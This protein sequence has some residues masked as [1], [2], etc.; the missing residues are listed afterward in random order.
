MIEIKYSYLQ[1]AER[2]Q[3]KKNFISL[4]FNWFG[5]LFY[6]LNNWHLIKDIKIA[7]SLNIFVV[8]R[9]RTVSLEKK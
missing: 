7:F 4:N 9:N 1:T 6:E 2:N 5:D 3:K 8:Q